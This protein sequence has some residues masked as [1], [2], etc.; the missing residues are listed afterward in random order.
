[1]SL[2]VAL[3]CVAVLLAL[4]PAA[5]AFSRSRYANSVVYGAS[6]AISVTIAATALLSLLTMAEVKETQVLPIGLPWL[7][8][9]FRLDNLSAF[10]LLVIN[11]GVHRQACSPWAMAATKMPL[12]VFCHFTRF[13]L[14]Q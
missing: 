8:A 4:G 13:S 5:I 6:L 14:R 1:M 10:F 7:G 12:N 3:G 11:F 2:H 9:H